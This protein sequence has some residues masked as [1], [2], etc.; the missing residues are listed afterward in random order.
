MFVTSNTT[1][2]AKW[3]SGTFTISASKTGSGTMSPTGNSTVTAGG[4]VT[5]SFSAASTYSIKNVKVDGV[6]V[7]AVTSYT[8]SNV[9]ANHTISVEFAPSLTI[10]KTSMIFGPS[11]GEDAFVITSYVGWTITKPSWISLSANSGTG[12]LTVSVTCSPYSAGT[13]SGTIT[14]TGGGVTKTIS[15]TQASVEP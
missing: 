10:N 14:I 12:S 7:G 11:G 3:I 8:F 6:S 2:Y 1:L 5:Y 15:V 9:I 4:S 13:R